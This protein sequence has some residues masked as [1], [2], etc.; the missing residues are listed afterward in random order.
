MRNLVSQK[1]TTNR[2]FLRT[3]NYPNIP[4]D[5]PGFEISVISTPSANTNIVRVNVVLFLFLFLSVPQISSATLISPRMPAGVDRSASYRQ[6]WHGRSTSK[7][8]PLSGS[9]LLSPGNSVPI[10][11]RACCRSRW[12]F[13][14]TLSCLLALSLSHSM[15]RVNDELDGH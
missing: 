11:D 1:L 5:R 7:R 9:C 12:A 2:L 6:M 8:A 13:D 3:L 14:G 10:D 15:Y 4:Y